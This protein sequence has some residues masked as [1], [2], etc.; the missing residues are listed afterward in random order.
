MSSRT[1]QQQLIKETKCS[2]MCYKIAWFR[3]LLKVSEVFLGHSSFPP[4]WLAIKTVAQPTK[5][6][7]REIIGALEPRSYYLL[8]SNSM[9]ERTSQLLTAFI[10]SFPLTL[11]RRNNATSKWIQ[12]LYIH[13]VLYAPELMSCSILPCRS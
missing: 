13:D 5:L 9:L 2:L 10:W 7:G 6:G 4:T 3:I 11:H 1:C 8:G 12:F